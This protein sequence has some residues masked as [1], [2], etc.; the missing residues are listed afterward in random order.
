MNLAPEHIAR[1]VKQPGR[2]Y[3][4]YAQKSRVPD[5]FQLFKADVPDEFIATPERAVWANVIKRTI[6]DLDVMV[7]RRQDGMTLNGT[8]MTR[9]LAYEWITSNDTGPRTFLW[10]CD[11]LSLDANRLRKLIL[12]PDSRKRMLGWR[13]KGQK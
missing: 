11:M 13:T 3:R 7:D 1:T 8:H 4:S 6:Q 5:A 10:A 2:A 12:Q 9:D